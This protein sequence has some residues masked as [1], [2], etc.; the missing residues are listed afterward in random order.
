MRQR[1]RNSILISVTFLLAGPLL[2]FLLHLGPFGA[3][4]SFISGDSRLPVLRVQTLWTDGKLY[5]LVVALYYVAG[6]I[7]AILAAEAT[8][9]RIRRTGRCPWWFSAAAGGIASLPVIA[10][11]VAVDIPQFALIGQDRRHPTLLHVPLTLLSGFFATALCWLL[12]RRRLD[13]YAD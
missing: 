9:F 8:K 6:F 7:P 10:L 13:Q 5:L 11:A 3:I 1:T 12:A 2:V 4:A